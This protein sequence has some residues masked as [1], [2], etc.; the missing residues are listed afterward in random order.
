MTR[1]IIAAALATPFPA[2]AQAAA[3]ER[4]GSSPAFWI[5]MLAVFIALGTVYKAN[6]KK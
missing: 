5:A 4:E 2:W 6:R 3:P 1:W